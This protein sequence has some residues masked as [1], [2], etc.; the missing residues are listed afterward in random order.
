MQ[1]EILTFSLLMQVG[2]WVRFILSHFVKTDTKWDNMKR[3]HCPTNKKKRAIARFFLSLLSH[4]VFIYR[5]YYVRC[6]IHDDLAAVE[7]D[8]LVTQ[9]LQG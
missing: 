5:Q 3:P 4:K 1:Y 6:I 7:P 9:V 8:D 2:Q